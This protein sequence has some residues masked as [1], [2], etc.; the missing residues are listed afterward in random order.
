MKHA[1][2]TIFSLLTL[3]ASALAG[4]RHFANVYETTT[5]AKGAIELENWVTWETRR[6][7]GDNSNLWKFRHEIEYGI[8]DR[9]QLGVYVANWTLTR[10]A[11]HRNS[12]RYES[13]AAELIYRLS[14][15]TTDALGS[16]V[17]LEIEGGHDLFALEGKLLLQKNIGRFIFAWNG[18]IEAEWSGHGLMER[19]GT[20]EQTL[21][22]SYQITP[23]VSV[24]GELVHE[25]SFDDWSKSGP[26]ILFAGPDISW[27]FKRGFI[28]AATLFQCTS[29][30]GEPDIQTRVI[31]GIHF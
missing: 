25:V 27:R 19:T 26:N 29:V 10:D 28:T 22:V 20:L 15:P 16:A 13:A 11:D 9:L 17:Y 3:A 23:Q 5:A 7:G 12:T 6:G 2:I 21:G 14:H 1:K 8:T 30:T 18:V 31:F 24:G 4:E